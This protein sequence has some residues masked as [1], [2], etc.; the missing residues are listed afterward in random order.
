M[1]RF[2][3]GVPLPQ[4]TGDR[5]AAASR[6]SPYFAN[7]SP[8]TQVSLYSLAGR[9]AFN[10]PVVGVIIT[11]IQLGGTFCRSSRGLVLRTPGYLDE[12]IKETVGWIALADH[13][14]E[15]EQAEKPSWPQNDKACGL[16]G[17]CMFRDVCSKDPS[18]R[19]AF[20][21]GDFTKQIWDPTQ[22]R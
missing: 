21:E 8:D 14:A 5:P 16:F 10:Q 11:G 15:R 7:Y 4:L 20:L 12:W 1:G 19:P 3:D 6:G 2:S 13:Y 22:S 18:V 17:G 9:V